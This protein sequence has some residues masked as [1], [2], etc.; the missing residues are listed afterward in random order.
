MVLEENVCQTVQCVLE[1]ATDLRVPLDPRLLALVST[2]LIDEGDGSTRINVSGGLAAAAQ[3]A[4]AAVLSKTPDCACPPGTKKCIL[5]LSAP[6]ERKVSA[7][8]GA[9]ARELVH[10]PV[11]IRLGPRDWAR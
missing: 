10:V 7:V 3:H 11:P 1:T 5:C 4:P 2:K 8:G 9:R 6:G